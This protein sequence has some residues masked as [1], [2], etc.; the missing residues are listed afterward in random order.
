MNTRAE[1]SPWWAERK[2]IPFIVSSQL[3][4]QEQ[5]EHLSS[6]RIH[7]CPLCFR[8]PSWGQSPEQE[9]PE[10]HRQSNP[11]AKLMQAES[12]QQVWVLKAHSSISAINKAWNFKTQASK[13]RK[14]QYTVPLSS[15]N[16]DLPVVGSFFICICSFTLQGSEEENHG[17]KAYGV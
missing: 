3:T 14:Q 11:P 2:N 4:L 1:R 6:L 16:S 10:G 9:G 5:T 13:L 15:T 17:T 12:F 7:T 8:P